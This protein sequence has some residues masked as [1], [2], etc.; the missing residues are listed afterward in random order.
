MDIFTIGLVILAI[1]LLY[2]MMELLVKTIIIF[3]TIITLFAIGWGVYKR[4][5]TRRYNHEQTN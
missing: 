3:A 4:R 5:K 2:R 1:A